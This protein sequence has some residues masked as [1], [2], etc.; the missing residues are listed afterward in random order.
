M[1]FAGGVLNCLCN[2]IGDRIAMMGGV[3][4][5]QD[6]VRP[7]IRRL[8]RHLKVTA[9]LISGICGARVVGGMQ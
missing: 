7:R 1:N 5:R 6:S 8:R 4:N 3:V 2:M 9:V